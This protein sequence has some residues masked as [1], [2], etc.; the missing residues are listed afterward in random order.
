MYTHFIIGG[1]FN[2]DPGVVEPH[3]VG[4]GDIQVVATAE[5]TYYSTQQQ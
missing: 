4:L 1:D 3:I 5:N 2:Q